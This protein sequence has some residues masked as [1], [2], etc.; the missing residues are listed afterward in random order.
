MGRNELIAEKLII[1][2]IP[3]ILWGSHS[4][5]LYLY[6]HGQNG[7]K[8]EAEIFADIACP[9]EWQVLSIDF[10]GHGERKSE[11]DSFDPWHT[12]PELTA[13]MEYAK[14]HWG[15]ISLYAN[16]IGAWFS[17][18]ACRDV[19]LENCLFV[20][21]VLDMKK[22]IANM[23]IWAAVSEEQLERELII[24]TSFG[25]TLSWEYWLYANH[26]PIVSWQA[27]T[28]I[29]Y[30]GKDTLTDRTTVEQFT[31]EFGCDLT[32]MEFGEHWFHTP[33]QLEVLKNWIM[34]CL[35]EQ[36][37]AKEFWK[38]KPTDRGTD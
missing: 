17:M 36:E 38:Q 26:H 16:S 21:P 29:L 3:A 33:K 15:K 27:S 6:L 13:V 4:D 37:K 28:K 2:N 12:V 32:V 19:K 9:Y 10:P 23:M 25:Q 34:T 30:G 20:S 7:C 31:R 35:Q 5:K 22:L 11:A 14:S 18:L 24:P 8:E 1:Y